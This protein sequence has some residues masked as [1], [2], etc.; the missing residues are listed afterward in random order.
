M[1]DLLIHNA[2]IVTVDR[3]D[4]VLTDACL[5]VADGRIAAI[6][7]HSADRSLPPAG[8][9][10]DAGGGI[11][12]PGLVNAHT[13]LPMALF[14]GLADDL[15][16]MTWLEGHIFPA[17]AAHI[18]PSNVVPAVRLACAEL[19]LGGVTTCCD[20][21]FLAHQVA[22]AVAEMGLRAVLGQ[23][24]VDFPAPGV[25]DPGQNV[26]VAADFVE[27]WSNKNPLIRPAIFCHAPYTC[28][29]QTLK[30]AKA[31]ARKTGVLFQIHVAETRDEVSQIRERHGCSPVAHLDN[32]GLLDDETLMVHCVWLTDEDIALAAA[33]D[34]RIVHCPE[35]NMKL[36]AGVAPL[37]KFLAAGLTVGLGTDGCASNNNQDLFKEMDMAAKLHKVIGGDPTAVS[38]ATALRMATIEGARAIGLDSRTGSLEV[39]KQAD[40][41]I[42]ESRHPRLQPLYNPVSQLVYTTDAGLV[43]DTIVDGRIRVRNHRLAGWDRQDLL[44]P[45]AAIARKIK[46]ADARHR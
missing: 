3:A 28:S 12:M 24:V 23:G 15:P 1:Y 35:S 20:G 10:I 42:L 19:L 44:A 22:S 45:V 16:L 31:A 25:S 36:G 29:P 6:A 41:V 2:T 43:R 14:R 11:V 7:G 9:T 18:T 17:E 13:H 32:L 40:I 33:R 39:G 34:A 21:Y 26:A 30:A 8:E 4:T 46:A 37:V 5:A 38:A 27:Y